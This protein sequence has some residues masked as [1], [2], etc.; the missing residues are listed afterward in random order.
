MYIILTFTRMTLQLSE[1]E[2]LSKRQN[3]NMLLTARE[4]GT[5]MGRNSPRMAVSA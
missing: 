5:R 3:D 4:K 2:R 1:S